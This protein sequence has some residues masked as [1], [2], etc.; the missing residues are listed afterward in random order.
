MLNFHRVGILNREG[1]RWWV[2]TETE[3]V[4]VPLAMLEG[5][6]GRVIVVSDIDPAKLLK[7][8]KTG[9]IEK[10]ASLQREVGNIRDVLDRISAAG[11]ETT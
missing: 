9:D 2:Q 3:E 10:L 6:R 1:D 8:L 7:E 4:D 11:K 5:H